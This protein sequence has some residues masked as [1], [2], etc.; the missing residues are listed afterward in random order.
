MSR[1]R[2]SGLAAVILAL[3]GA[4]WLA[5]D[6]FDPPE[7]AREP[8]PSEIEALKERTS[9]PVT[10]SHEPSASVESPVA[11]VASGEVDPND[12]MDWHAVADGPRWHALADSLEAVD[13]PMARPARELAR[14]VSASRGDDDPAAWR[15]LV[16][17]EGQLVGYL[18]TQALDDDTAAKVAALRGALDSLVRTPAP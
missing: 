18:E 9:K 2:D 11:S 12:P 8:T 7:E 13:D 14:R 17:E 3:I 16:H 10:R 15:A 5:W 1:A 6:R 4:G